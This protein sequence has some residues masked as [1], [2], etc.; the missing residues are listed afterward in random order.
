[1]SFSI[2]NLLRHCVNFY[3]LKV[4]TIIRWQVS[5]ERGDFQNAKSQ[6]QNLNV[7]FEIYL[8]HLRGQDEVLHEVRIKVRYTEKHTSCWAAGTEH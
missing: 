8:S 3:F 2:L 6:T 7:L 1:M 5:F 4:T